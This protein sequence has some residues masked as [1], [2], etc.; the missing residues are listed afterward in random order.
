VAEWK[1]IEV[2]RMSEALVQEDLKVAQF[3][4]KSKDK[5][6]KRNPTN[7]LSEKNEISYERSEELQWRSIYHN[8]NCLLDESLHFL[9]SMFFLIFF[10]DVSNRIKSTSEN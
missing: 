3:E 1:T 9:L 5:S 4:H 10:H 6:K 8:L 7:S 2:K